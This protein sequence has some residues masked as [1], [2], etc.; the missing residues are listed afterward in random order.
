MPPRTAAPLRRLALPLAG[1]ACGVSMVFHEAVLTGLRKMDGGLGDARLINFILEHG[2]RW[3]SGRPPHE[4]FWSPPVF[5]P[6]ENVAAYSDVLLGVGPFYWVWRWLG[7]DPPTAFQLW[8]LAMW[9]LNF[10]AIYL[11]VRRYLGCG[12]PAATLAAV[13]Y[14]FGGARVVQ[15]VHP[16]LVPHFWVVLAFAA[17]VEAFG[18]APD[19]APR[20]P[21]AVGAWIGVFFAAL[22]LQAW[23]AFYPFYFALALGAAALAWALVFSGT[24]A[25]LAAFWRARRTAILVAAAG[26]ALLLWPLAA[27]YLAA[28]AERGYFPFAERQAPRLA[29]WL[30]PGDTNVAWGWLTDLSVFEGLDASPHWN[31]VGFVTLAVAAAGLTRLWRRPG[32]RLLVLAVATLFVLTL[33]WPGEVSLWRWVREVA[34]GASALR[35]VAR[36]GSVLTLPAALGLAAFFDRP[37]SGRRAATALLALLGLLV[38]AEQVHA[39][40][41]PLD[42]AA[43]R[44]HVD[45]LARR[46]DPACR[47]FLLVMQGRGRYEHLQDD[48]AWVT[49]ATGIPTVNGR[50][51]SF[52]P[53]YPNLRMPRIR[54]AR[55]LAD[56]RRAMRGWLEAHG[57]SAEGVCFV[58]VDEAEVERSA[59]RVRPPAKV[60]PRRRGRRE[61]GERRRRRPRFERPE[62]GLVSGSMA[63]VAGENGGERMNGG[64]E[65]AKARRSWLERLG[66]KIPGFRGYQDREL[67]RDVDKLQ[68]EHLSAEIG[69]LKVAER[70]KARAYTDAGKIGVLHLFD[71]LDRRLDGLSQAVRYAD[72]G[73]SGLFDPVKIYDEELEKLYQFDLSVLDDLAGLAGDVA[74]IPVPGQGDAEGALEQALGRLETLVEKWARRKHVISEVVKTSG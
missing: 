42:K 33:S 3:L 31:G 30:L 6:H 71:R 29:S 64:F 72:Y 73:Q 17:L 47:A 18:A 22:V 27:R 25:R 44:A 1:W 57:E 24:R 11:V 39:R 37:R 10:V 14:A 35:A 5:F 55:R 63:P 62:E 70:G 34:P 56:A 23:T 16:Q 69:R 65:E 46:V 74:A 2:Y 48:A 4:A 26:A 54:K 58:V 7:A 52:P 60:G 12:R 32:V 38:L 8:T 68:R 67:R 41:T 50:Y 40:R 61:P 53:E 36:V 21:A 43:L 49:L 66:E 51:G 20:R 45:S 15:L 13:V 9:T 59:A 19:G 28:K